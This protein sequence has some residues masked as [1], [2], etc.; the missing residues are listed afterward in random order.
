MT[1]LRLMQAE[2]D[3]SPTL[4]R[5]KPEASVNMATLVARMKANDQLALEALYDDTVT[6]VYGFALTFVNSP[7]D[8]EEI[9]EDVYFRA[10]RDADRF[11]AERGSV[12]TWLL[13]MCRSIALDRLR[14]AGRGE[15][16]KRAI[17]DESSTDGQI[18]SDL[19]WAADGSRLHDA[20]KLLSRDQAQVLQLAY[21]RGYSHSEIAT[22]LDMSLGTVKTHIRRTI[23]LLRRQLAP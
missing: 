20:M 17:R 6:R 19:S 2:E 23:E 14:A 13:I 15:R 21:F 18:D 3:S 10:W 5:P 1:T 22:R 4:D 9:T 12:M 11:D 7:A 16:T 8:A